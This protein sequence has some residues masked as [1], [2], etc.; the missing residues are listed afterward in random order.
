MEEIPQI[1]EHST[2][3]LLPSCP[4]QSLL[5]TFL[6]QH[7]PLTAP[8]QLLHKIQIAKTRPANVQGQLL[9]RD[10]VNLTSISGRLTPPCCTLFLKSAF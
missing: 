5:L 2:V 4:P 9:S 6:A 3:A 7:Q 1:G 8:P 10:H